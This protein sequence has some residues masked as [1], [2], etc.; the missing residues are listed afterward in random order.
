MTFLQATDFSGIINTATLNSLRGDADVN[1]DKAEQL[2]ISE[3]APL[4][5]TYNVAG[6]LGKT[7]GDRN[8]ELIRVMVHLTAYYLYNTV[9]DVGIP[10][11][12]DENYSTQRKD[13]AKIAS[14]D[15]HTT[16]TPL[17]VDGERK[18]TY[19]FGGDVP[20]DNQI[21]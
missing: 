18:G 21:F 19:F 1:L 3:L 12:I 17:T 4:H 8:N 5:Y 9:E 14:G 7:G 2:A 20:R 15:L 11:R 13:I 16:I 6:E 10:E